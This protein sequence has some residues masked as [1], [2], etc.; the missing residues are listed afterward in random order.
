MTPD[1]DVKCAHCLLHARIGLGKWAHDPT[2]ENILTYAHDLI[3]EEIV[4]PP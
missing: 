1:I 3:E 2:L 4:F